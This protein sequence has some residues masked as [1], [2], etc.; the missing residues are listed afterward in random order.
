MIQPVLMLIVKQLNDYLT[1]L[2]S[3]TTP[4]TFVVVGNVALTSA[5]SG[6]QGNYMDNKIVL[7]LVNLIEESSLK[8]SSPYRISSLNAEIE[9]PPIFINAYLLFTANFPPET[10]GDNIGL[11]YYKGIMQLTRVIEFFQGKKEFTTK[12]S[13][14]VD[15]I[16]DTATIESP[17]IELQDLSIKM[18]MTS[19]TF[20]QIN[21]LWGSLGGKQ[22]PFVLFKAH[23]IPIKRPNL[24]SKGALIQDVVADFPHLQNAGQ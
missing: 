17:P 4:T 2:S 15:F 12:N 22:L 21:Y 3:N 8:N 14:S 19:L 9:N 7:S 6:G 16:P 10:S 23:V 5:L 18:E 11:N 20:E 1:S 13:P 24:L